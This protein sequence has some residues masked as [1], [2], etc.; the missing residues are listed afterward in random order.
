MFCELLAY[1]AQWLELPSHKRV[2]TGSN[3]VVGILQNFPCSYLR[4]EF[5]GGYPFST[6]TPAKVKQGKNQLF[7][8]FFKT[9]RLFS[10]L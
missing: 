2:V 5:G 7:A 10:A 8:F 9:F 3:L 6:S 4:G 1:L